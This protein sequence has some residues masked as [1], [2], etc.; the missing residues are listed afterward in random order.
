MRVDDDLDLLPP[1]TN[2]LQFAQ[3]LSLGVVDLCEL[4]RKFVAD[5]GFNEHQ[6]SKGAD[7]DRIRA[8]GDSIQS[9]CPHFFSP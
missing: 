4:L 3:Q 6:S 1:Y 8:T 5:T 2:S 7:Q 9:I